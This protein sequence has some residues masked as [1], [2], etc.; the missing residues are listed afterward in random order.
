MDESPARFLREKKNRC[1]GFREAFFWTLFCLILAAGAFGWGYIYR[2]YRVDDL[3]EQVFRIDSRQK[4]MEGR[5]TALEGKK[6]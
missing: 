3:R 1:S 4:A 5:L 6:K 2:D